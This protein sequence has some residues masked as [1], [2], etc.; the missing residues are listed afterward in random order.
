MS[1]F[2]HYN[3]IFLK[4]FFLDIFLK[5]Q[6]N[7]NSVQL[8]VELNEYIFYHCNFSFLPHKNVTIKR[9]IKNEFLF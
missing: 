3:F 8:P 1:G 5:I 6:Q 4:T 9:K 7:L 2:K